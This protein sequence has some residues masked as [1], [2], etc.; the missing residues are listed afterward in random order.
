M[1]QNLTQVEYF[2]LYDRLVRFAEGVARRHFPYDGSQ[3]L[4]ATDN[5]LAKFVTNAGFK[6][7][8]DELVYDPQIEDIVT[9]GKTTIVN[10]IKNY[11]RDNQLLES[12]PLP[13]KELSDDE[14]DGFHGYQIKEME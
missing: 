11:R 8:G 12:I 4:E 9:W 7:V 2:K 5:A 6:Q 14:V 1:S 3:Q 10:A 13:Y